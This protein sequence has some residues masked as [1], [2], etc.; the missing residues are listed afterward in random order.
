MDLDTAEVVFE[1]SF[2]KDAM[3]CL[4]TNDEIK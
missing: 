2:H 4:M 1:P 3:E